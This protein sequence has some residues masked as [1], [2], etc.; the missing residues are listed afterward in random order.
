MLCVGDQ[1]VST[2]S[3]RGT[4]P[5]SGAACFLVTD[6]DSEMVRTLNWINLF[7]TGLEV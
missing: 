3:T 5:F 1:K 2:P 7:L 4:A 6:A